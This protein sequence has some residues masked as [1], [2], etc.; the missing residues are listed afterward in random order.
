M[1][2]PV[3]D[4]SRTVA[5]VLVALVEEPVVV[6][7]L[8]SSTCTSRCPVAGQMISSWSGLSIGADRPTALS[9][10]G[11]VKCISVTQQVGYF[12]ALFCVLRLA[13]NAQ[14]VRVDMNE[15]VYIYI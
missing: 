9:R 1:A 11:A 5:L 8:T 12:S 14:L 13:K 2:G 15:K 10:D 6:S 3:V 4:G 7:V